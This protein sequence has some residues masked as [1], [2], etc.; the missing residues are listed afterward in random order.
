MLMKCLKIQGTRGF[1]FLS[2][3]VFYFS[4]IDTGK[5]KGTITT[6]TNLFHHDELFH[7]IN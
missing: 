2:L 5:A 4:A 1:V 7:L 3:L 6:S